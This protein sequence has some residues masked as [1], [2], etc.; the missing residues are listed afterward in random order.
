MRFSELSLL[1]ALSEPVNTLLLLA[2]GIARNIGAEWWVW[3]QIGVLLLI[4]LAVDIYNQRDLV[5]RYLSRN[6]RVDLVYALVDLF[7]IIHFTVLI[8][9]G[10][11]LSNFLKTH[12]SW[13]Q[14]DV[15]ANLPD[16]AQLLIIFLFADF[17]V[18]WYH[19]WQHMSEVM[20]QFHKTH[21]SQKHM[22]A[23]T[24]F[25]SSI[26]DRIVTLSVL[27]VPGAVLST[28]YAMPLA[29]LTIISAH[30]LV[31]HTAT[32]WTFGW[33]GRLVVSPAFHEV[34]HSTERVY[35]DRNFGGFLTIWDRIFGTAVD[36]QSKSRSWGVKNEIIP[37]S[38][39]LQMFVPIVG[40]Y[41]LAKRAS[42][43]RRKSS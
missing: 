14:I 36:L 22:T 25:R 35:L 12:A 42:Q 7:H 40:L 17:W 10:L 4:G 1:E 6:F 31:I 37:E 11:L 15:L 2:Q 43:A 20:W 24:S 19:R 23:I 9:L 34:H 21:H 39:I 32:G 28:S 41:R 5:K 38:Y 33:L 27:S 8:P 29:A 30:Q 3:A 16:W 18:Y 26:L 13:L